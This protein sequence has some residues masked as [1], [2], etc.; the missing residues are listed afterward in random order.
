MNLAEKMALDCGVKISIPTIDTM[1]MPVKNDNYIIIDSRSK[2]KD[3][4]YDYYHDVLNLIAKELQ[5]NNIEVFQ[6][7]NDNNRKLNCDKCFITINKKQEAYLIANCKLI[8]TNENYTSLIA[9]ALNVKS[10]GLYSI[11]YSQNSCP[12]WNKDSHTILESNRDKNKP[13]FNTLRE[14]PK[15]INFI[16]PYDIAKN[17]LDILGIKNNLHKFDIVNIGNSYNEK[18]VEVVPDFISTPEFLNN[19]QINLRL[20]YIDSLNV[21]VFNY[22]IN[23]K[24]VNLITDKD[25][26][27]NL[28]LPFKNNIL[29]ITIMVS[30]NISENFLQKCKFHGFKIKLF[31][32]DKN[33]LKEYRFKF[34][35][36]QIHQDFDDNRKLSNFSNINTNSK[37]VSSKILISKGQQYSCRAYHL[38]QKPLDKNN[39]TVIF[40]KEFEEELEFYK[41]YNERK[42]ES[43]SGTSI[44]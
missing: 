5:E 31:C 10:I 28:L 22:W 7:A 32:N 34:L 12:V 24:K 43:T 37:F 20:D 18:I 9:A 17:I 16:S 15:T 6:F 29:L 25:I 26:N 19:N 4:E 2:Y 30:E 23:N 44:A 14:K 8:V 13:S 3:A 41:I 35:D 38:A 42:E 21:S 36:W 11:Y 1:L 39:E 27:I 33:K 40:S